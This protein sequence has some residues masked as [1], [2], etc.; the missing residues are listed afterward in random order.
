[1]VKLRF[2]FETP[3]KLGTLFTSV[4]LHG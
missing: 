3:I 2:V 4:Q 1:M